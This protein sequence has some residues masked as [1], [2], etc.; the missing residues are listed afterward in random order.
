MGRCRT[1][2][3][4]FILTIGLGIIFSA[5]ALAEI[6]DIDAVL[7]KLRTQATAV[8]SISS[9]FSQENRLSVFEET[10]VSSGR[11][12]FRKPDSLRW[13]YLSPI[14]EGFAL[15]G[16]QGV[17]WTETT[18]TSF[19]LR[20]D[21][22]MNVVARQLLAWATFDLAWLSAEYDITLEADSPV[23]LKLVPK[24]S[25]TAQV[26]KHLLIEFSLSS[27]TVQRVELHDQSGDL[28]RILFKN[29]QV[30]TPLDDG[31]FR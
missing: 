1:L 4:H 22:L 12:L 9:E 31:M 13:E 6:R 15:Q 29:P 30:N 26:L 18:R 8:E 11:F 27:N 16:N 28:T 19:S 24:S 14:T 23:L 25:D 2:A 5:H 10:I 20:N 3:F 7:Q 17:R 21:P